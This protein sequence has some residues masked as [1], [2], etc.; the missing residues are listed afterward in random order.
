[1]HKFEWIFFIV[2]PYNLFAVM[3]S[4]VS[5]QVIN[6]TVLMV[7]WDLVG[8]SRWN[9]HHY[10]I[11]YSAFSPVLYKVIDESTIEVPPNKISEAVV[12]RELE[13]GV[14]HQFQVTASLEIQGEV[15]EGEKSIL[16]AYSRVVFGK[17][18][19]LCNY[20]MANYVIEN[21]FCYKPTDEAAFHLQM[22]PVS[23]CTTWSVSVCDTHVDMS[24][25]VDL[26]ATFFFV[27]S[28]D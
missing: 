26:C 8:Q 25:G 22:G 12:I 14:E 6:A 2:F 19:L 5:V 11:Y 18:D 17:P 20:S 4:N 1:M 9:I 21:H 13:A 7:S 23:P 16:T 24:G 27:F 28:L 15:Y 3:V 10:T